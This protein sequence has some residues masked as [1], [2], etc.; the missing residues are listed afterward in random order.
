MADIRTISDISNAVQGERLRRGMS[1]EE[2]AAQ[3]GV[4]RKWV[5][6]FEAGQ[7]GARLRHVLAAL[8]ALGLRL[9]LQGAAIDPGGAEPANNVD[10]DA[11]LDS[12]E[13]D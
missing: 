9:S 4:S 7:P 10:L 8:N 1:Q 2:L 13:Q 5:V 6:D 11:L 12:Y 3:I